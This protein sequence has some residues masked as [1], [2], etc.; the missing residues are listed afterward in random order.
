V[1]AI[2]QVHFPFGIDLIKPNGLDISVE[3][4]KLLNTI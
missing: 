4:D 1:I 3:T 2:L